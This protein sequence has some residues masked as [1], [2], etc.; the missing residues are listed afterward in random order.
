MAL[1]RDIP[2]RHPDSSTEMRK[3]DSCSTT[4]LITSGTAVYSKPAKFQD[5]GAGSHAY[6]LRILPYVLP[7]RWLASTHPKIPR[8]GQGGSFTCS[9]G[10]HSDAHLSNARDSFT[11]FLASLAGGRILKRLS[12]TQ[13]IRHWRCLTALYSTVTPSYSCC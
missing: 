10:M 5:Q 12:S 4:G 9:E 11:F 2:T 8:C 6:D 3:S 13:L 1:S 7:I